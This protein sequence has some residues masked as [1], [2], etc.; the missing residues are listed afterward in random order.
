MRPQGAIEIPKPDMKTYSIG[1]LDRR[2]MMLAISSK[3]A[4][5]IS[6]MMSIE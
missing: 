1:R 6:E 3:A 5:A 2:T 4:E